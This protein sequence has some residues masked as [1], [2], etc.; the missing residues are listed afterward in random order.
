MNEGSYNFDP[1]FRKT[2]GLLNTGRVIVT[3]RLHGSIF[4]FLMNKP[5]VILDQSY[6]KITN[7]REVAFGVSPSC[8]DKKKLRYEK[9]SSLEEAVSIASD[10]LNTYF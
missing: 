9:A 10:M 8:S 1:F 2:L 4:A 6:N 3:D 5:H 7:T